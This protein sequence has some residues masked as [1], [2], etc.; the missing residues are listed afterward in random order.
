MRNAV[1]EGAQAGSK[2]ARRIT[3]DMPMTP[4]LLQKVKN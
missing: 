4:P 2:I 3:S 1:L